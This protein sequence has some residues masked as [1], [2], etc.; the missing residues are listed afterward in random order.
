MDE[1]NKDELIL[2]EYRKLKRIMKPIGREQIKA[3]DD[4]LQRLAFMTITLSDLEAD[5]K[6]K[7]AIVDFENGKQLMRIEN[8]AQKSYNTMIN[9]YNALYSTIL[10]YLAK[11]IEPEKTK[12]VSDGFDEFVGG[13]R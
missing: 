11:A 7:G 4:L 9:R 1:K 13:G 8:P 3:I 12:Q 10:G 2:K 5:I 6:V